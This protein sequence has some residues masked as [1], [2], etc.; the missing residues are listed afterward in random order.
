MTRNPNTRVEDLHA[1]QAK[2]VDKGRDALT[3]GSLFAAGFIL[4][5]SFIAKRFYQ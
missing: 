1:A 3:I 5:V 4:V 2:A